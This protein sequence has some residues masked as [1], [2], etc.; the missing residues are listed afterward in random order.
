MVGEEADHFVFITAMQS[1][2]ALHGYFIAF[3]NF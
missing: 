2:L 1:V 3:G